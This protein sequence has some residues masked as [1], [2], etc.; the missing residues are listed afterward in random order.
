MKDCRFLNSVGLVASLLLSFSAFGQLDSTRLAKPPKLDFFPAI[1]FS[2]ETKLTLGGIG[3]KYFDF[4]KND[5]QTPLSTLEFFAVYTTAKQVLVEGRWEFF[6]HQKTWRTR[7][8]AI[9]NHYSDRNY[10]IGNDAGMLLATELD[11]KPDTLN[12]LRFKV[13]RWK[14]SPVV[15]RKIG[16]ALWLG[17]QYD[18]E[19][20]WNYQP[21]PDAYHFLNADSVRLLDLPITGTRAGAGLQLLYDTRDFVSNPLHGS[22]I[23]FNALHY[24]KW[25]GADYDYARLMV[26]AR[27]YLNT[28]SNQT[29]A[30]RGMLSVQFSEGQIPWRALSR[31]NGH[32][33]IRGYF[34]G[35]YQDFNM[36]AFELEYRLPFWKENNGSKT[37]E[38]WKRLGIVGF[39]SGV[40]TFHEFDD[41]DLGQFNYAAGGGLRILL[42][43][44][45]RVNIRVDYAFGLS[46]GSDGPGKRQRGLYFFLAEAF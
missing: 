43:K 24:H 36:A 19:K 29:L 35:T 23:E 6:T 27:Q 34:R 20:L 12:Y 4:L 1:S 8:E 9:Y 39:F 41:F 37:W 44:S 18:Y 38:V 14:F 45:S 21:V 3:I 25:L 46:K 28:F 13:G 33:L 22:L 30:L 7:G 5:F 10:G 17:L 42:N 15:L 2:P 32:K 16:P 31:T 26:D 11:G 40:E